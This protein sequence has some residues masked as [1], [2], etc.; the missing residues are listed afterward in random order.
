MDVL[1][2][3]ACVDL[4]PGPPARRTILRQVE[5]LELPAAMESE[6]KAAVKQ[7][8]ETR[9]SMWALTRSAVGRY[10]GGCFVRPGGK[11]L[12]RWHWGA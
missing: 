5:N 11:L 4:L 8:F 3:L 6:L 7:S 10:G 9:G 12:S 1:T 2:A